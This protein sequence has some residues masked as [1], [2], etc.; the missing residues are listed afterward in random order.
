MRHINVLL[1]ECIERI[2]KKAQKHNQTEAHRKGIA[3][4]RRILNEDKQEKAA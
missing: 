2:D 3:E 1:R 4:A